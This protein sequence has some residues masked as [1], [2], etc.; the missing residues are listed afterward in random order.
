[1]LD[2]LAQTYTYTTT[3]TGDDAAAAGVFAL[4]TGVFF[5]VWLALVVVMVVSMWKIFEKAGVEGWKAIIPVYNTWV[6][7]E[8]SGRPGWW[9]LVGLAGI[10]PILGIFASIAAF[11]LY[12]LIAIDLVKSFGKE[13]IW[14]LL[15]ILV[16]IVGFPMLAF[17]DAKYKGPAGPEGKSGGAKPKAA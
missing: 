3:T 6:L 1:M 5:F 4:F 14:A 13:P 16:P 10:I 11:V 15:I 2:L 7:A 9:A 17:G 8:I 12:I